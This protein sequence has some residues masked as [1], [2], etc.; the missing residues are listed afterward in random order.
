MSK[1]IENVRVVRRG[2]DTHATVTFIEDGRRKRT[3]RVFTPEDMS[4]MTA[5]L[6][7]FAEDTVT[8]PDQTPEGGLAT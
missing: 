7:V 1:V 4:K 8:P 3:G 6:A 2:R 5:W